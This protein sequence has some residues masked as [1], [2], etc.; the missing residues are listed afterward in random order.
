MILLLHV[1]KD[2]EPI[3]SCHGQASC[4]GSWVQEQE[5]ILGR[6]DEVGAAGEVERDGRICR[7]RDSLCRETHIEAYGRSIHFRVVNCFLDGLSYTNVTLE[8]RKE[9]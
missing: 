9:K 6:K 2:T 8:I 7:I 3:D 5:V 4:V 1:S